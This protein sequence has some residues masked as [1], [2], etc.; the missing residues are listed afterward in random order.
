[1]KNLKTILM[2]LVLINSCSIDNTVTEDPNANCDNGTYVGEVRLLTQEE[3]NTFGENCYT[4]IDGTLFIGGD[5]SQPTDITDLSPLSSLTEIF[6]TGTTTIAKIWVGHNP[7]LPNLN[8]LQ[9]ITKADGIVISTNN[10][11]VDLSG[12]EGLEQLDGDGSIQDIIIYRNE[13]LQS[14]NGLDNIEF[15]GS[16][17]SF[18]TA[19]INIQGNNSLNNLDALQN[20]QNVYGNIYI[21]FTNQSGVVTDGNSSLTDYCGLSNVLANGVYETVIIDNNAYNPTVQ[22][23]IDG[24]CSQ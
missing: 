23:I 17:N 22:D 9:N 19:L 15:I 24:N 21:G 7:M 4:K 6:T 16:A 5:A 3:V 13:N 8:G 1:M 11:L 20:L 10:L 2:L 18:G 12:L 14:L